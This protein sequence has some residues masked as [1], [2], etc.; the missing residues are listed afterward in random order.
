ML[1]CL[2]ADDVATTNRPTFPRWAAKD[3]KT[4]VPGLEAYGVQ[5]L[6]DMMRYEPSKRITA[7]AALHHPYFA[8]LDKTGMTY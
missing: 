6:T 7:K 1:T 8:D 4:V 3:L 2:N 5:L